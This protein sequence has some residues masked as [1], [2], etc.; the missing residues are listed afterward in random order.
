MISMMVS[1][2]RC[3]T[4]PLNILLRIVLI[5]WLGLSAA[6]A[7]G[8]SVGKASVRVGEEGSQL[9]AN[10]D[11]NLT[12]VVQ[13]ALSRG[14]PLY[15]TAEF[16]VT[17]ARWYWLDEEVFSSEQVTKLSYNVLTR[18]YRLSRGA[19]YQNFSSLEGALNVM[20]RQSSTVMPMGALQKDGNY[21]ASVR[22]RLDT[23]QLPRLLQVNALTGKD[24]TLDSEW[25]R[26]V[27]RPVAAGD[28]GQTE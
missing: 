24:W 1:S 13:Q 22:L 23:S 7:Q 14:I 19:L 5:A 27:V 9:V 3:C 21:I 25:Y 2:M 20:S 11:I 10:Y 8:I 16:S 4:R 28:E 15:F 18:Q 17:L 6:Y 12:F 26:W